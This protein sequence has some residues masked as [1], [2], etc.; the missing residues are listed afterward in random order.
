MVASGRHVNRNRLQVRSS[1]GFAVRRVAHGPYVRM[2]LLPLRKQF[3][4]DISGRLDFEGSAVGIR[5]DDALAS[6]DELEIYAAGVQCDDLIV[7]P[8]R[9]GTRVEVHLDNPARK[10][11]DRS[12][13]ARRRRIS[14]SHRMN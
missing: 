14:G 9:E 13:Y 6:L 10:G 4:R 8:Y 1:R 3:L 5:H 2:F 7:S 11:L 12:R